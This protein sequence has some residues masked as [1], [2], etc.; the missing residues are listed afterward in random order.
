MGG[1]DS[2]NLE[3]SGLLLKFPLAMDRFHPPRSTVQSTSLVE[4]FM[5]IIP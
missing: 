4:E 1:F 5:S 3:V 2:A